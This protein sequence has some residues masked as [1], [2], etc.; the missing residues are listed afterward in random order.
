MSESLKSE[1]EYIKTLAEKGNIAPSKIG[2]LL[3]F[4]GGAFVLYFVIFLIGGRFAMSDVASLTDNFVSKKSLFKFFFVYL[5][6]VFLVLAL[7]IGIWKRDLILGSKAS[8]AAAISARSVWVGIVLFAISK[9]L[10]AMNV[11]SNPDNLKAMLDMVSFEPEPIGKFQ[12]GMMIYSTST[13]GLDFMP[14]AAIGWWVIGA[15][16]KTKWLQVL[17]VFGL[18]FAPILALN[19]GSLYKHPLFLQLPLYV[20]LYLII[21]ASILVFKPQSA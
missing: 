13:A 6:S 21:P 10:I 3:L 9:F 18:I 16:S 8:S 2:N 4:G 5:T 11:Q 20:F 15:T 19:F 1:I 14:L 12:L 7:V 17:A